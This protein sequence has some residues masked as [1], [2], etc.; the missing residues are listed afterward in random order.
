MNDVV[1]A[2][3][4][5]AAGVEFPVAVV[6][7]GVADPPRLTQWSGETEAPNSVTLRYQKD[8]VQITT[9]PEIMWGGDLIE[10]WKDLKAFV[11]SSFG[12][13]W[14]ARESGPLDFEGLEVEETTWTRTEKGYTELKV[15][16]SPPEKEMAEMRSRRKQAAAEAKHRVIDLS[17]GG[18]FVETIVVGE[19][20]MWSAG[21][22]TTWDDG[23]LVVLL[24][25]GA[26][27][28]DSLKLELVDDLLAYLQA[29]A[30]AA[31]SEDRP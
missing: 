13:A 28:V 24:T 19:A 27:A 15:Y 31:Q 14:E 30:A 26:V 23:P 11:E 7:D 21:F 9:Y 22:E 5:A 6:V 20:D 18:S 17:L 16:E 10:I 3:A 8:D 29:R 4:A 12:S 1:Q 2:W 25:G